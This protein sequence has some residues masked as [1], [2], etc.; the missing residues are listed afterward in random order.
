MNPMTDNQLPAGEWWTE[1]ADVA[2]G[3]FMQAV[4]FEAHATVV[5][6][7]ET[8]F[9]PGTLQTPEYMA[10][11]LRLVCPH[12]TDAEIGR[13]VELRRAR[14]HVMFHRDVKLRVVLDEAALLRPIGGKETMAA[15][16]R[17]LL[18]LM[19]HPNITL[20]VVR[21]NAPYVALGAP[22][23]VMS[24]PE[25]EDGQM[26]YSE[27]AFG[28]DVRTDRAAV[29]EAWNRLDDVRDAAED[30]DQTRQLLAETLR[31]H[32]GRIIGWTAEP[33]RKNWPDVVH[34]E[35]PRADP[36]GPLPTRVVIRA[37]V[38]GTF[39]EAEGATVREAEE[40]CWA[41]F[42]RFCECPA[43]PE[44]GPFEAGEHRDGSGTCTG[45]DIWFTAHYAGLPH[46][47]AEMDGP[48]PAPQLA[49]IADRP[50]RFRR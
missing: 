1:Y 23:M 41:R 17:F 24:R 6:Q 28:C 40:A 38:H 19:D 44:H 21:L 33:V 36:D 35:V 31:Y 9:V 4:A 42:R 43:F 8:V 13:R 20:Q 11:I 47:D 5:G 30:A 32:G 48:D 22:F 16:L 46:L 15:Q 45:C 34:L 2:S 18:D 12:L 49:E 50:R 7:F 29:E 14:Q 27:T 10:A 26:V 25:G 39:L 3:P 37:Y